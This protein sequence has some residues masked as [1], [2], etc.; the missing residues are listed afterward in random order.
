M[1]V[2]SATLARRKAEESWWRV[3]GQKS[4]E[5]FLKDLWPAAN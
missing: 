1:A 2:A 3:R 4:A 5:R